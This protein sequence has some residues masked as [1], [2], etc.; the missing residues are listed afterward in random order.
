METLLREQDS[1]GYVSN[2][3]KRW[4]EVVIQNAYNRKTQHQSKGPDH[5]P[6]LKTKHFSI[7]L[8]CLQVHQTSFH[9]P[10][11][12]LDF[13]SKH[14]IT[15]KLCCFNISFSVYSTMKFVIF[16]DS[17]YSFFSQLSIQSLTMALKFFL[18]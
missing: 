3:W 13:L 5:Q 18:S 12:A 2:Y 11:L 6:R 16:Q 14:F 9:I 1:S 17:P 8:V 15:L 7:F 4:D 10:N